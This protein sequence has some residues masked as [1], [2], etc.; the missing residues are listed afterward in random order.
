MNWRRWL[1]LNGSRANGAEL[2]FRT[3]LPVFGEKGFPEDYAVID[4][5]GADIGGV[6]PTPEPSPPPMP[7]WR[8]TEPG[9]KVWYA[10]AASDLEALGK[11]AL[12]LGR[13]EFIARME[14]A[15]LD[16]EVVSMTGRDAR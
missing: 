12:F 1:G 4:L 14:R 16:D 7:R 6:T 15:P 11:V 13:E 3:P 2:S 5:S 8:I 10:Y 9:G